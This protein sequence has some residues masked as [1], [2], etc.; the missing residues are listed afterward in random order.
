MK[1]VFPIIPAGNGP[2]WIL[3]ALALLMIGL[4]AVFSWFVYS[5]RNTRVEISPDGLA[6]RGTMYGRLIA[7]G[8]LDLE[9][10]RALDL[11]RDKDYRFKWRT[12]GV[13]LPGYQAGWF[14]LRGGGKA[15]AFLTDRRRVACVPTRQ[16]YQVMLSVSD[17]AAFLK[18]LR[19]AAGQK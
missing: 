16:G 9:G 13:G 4:V 15:L 10:A 19:R 1:E 3:I 14:K 5:S 8:D 17:P 2:V 12:N 7:L 6:I 18:S 11:D